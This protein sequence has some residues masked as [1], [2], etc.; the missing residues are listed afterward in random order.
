MASKM[1]ARQF[2]RLA[3]RFNRE[4]HP[5][6][7]EPML[8]W[9]EKP[10]W[11]ARAHT[12]SNYF[13]SKNADGQYESYLEL[14]RCA[15]DHGMPEAA[16]CAAGFLS[17]GLHDLGF[18][19]RELCERFVREPQRLMQLLIRNL[20]LPAKWEHASNIS[21]AQGM[22]FWEAAGDAHVLNLHDYRWRFDPRAPSAEAEI[23]RAVVRE[24]LPKIDVRAAS[25]ERGPFSS[26][27]S[28][29]LF[30]SDSLQDLVDAA[31][32]G[33]LLD[34]RLI[35]SEATIMRLESDTHRLNTR[36]E[37]A[38]IEFSLT[39]KRGI[40]PWFLRA[41]GD[42]RPVSSSSAHAQPTL[43]SGIN[44]KPSIENSQIVDGPQTRFNVVQLYW[45]D[46]LRKHGGLSEFAR[47]A[48]IPEDGLIR[49]IGPDGI[50]MSP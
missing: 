10:A 30:Y 46:F 22:C 3:R 34:F 14:I 17:E 37:A 9:L 45:A 42:Q 26:M 1:N 48:L 5:E 32:K 49:V 41:S 13:T 15:V 4:S 16:A 8:E 20:E 36:F 25:M 31:R 43:H 50:P 38:E 6:V 35:E 27:I 29:S 21:N 40:G 19:R 47:S 39:R 44:S 24:V 12:P 7:V 18:I 2:F 23:W 28:P 33:S 11:S